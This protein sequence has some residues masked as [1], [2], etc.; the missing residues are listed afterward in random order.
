MDISLA[1]RTHD[2]HILY[3]RSDFV[4]QP[5]CIAGPL[6]LIEAWNVSYRLGG[7]L[8]H[9]KHYDNEEW[10][11]NSPDMSNYGDGT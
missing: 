2:S 10:S 6:L 4:L 11:A 1:L 7:D 9:T 3:I 8:A 5:S